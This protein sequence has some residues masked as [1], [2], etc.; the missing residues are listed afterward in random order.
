MN[1]PMVLNV[2][3][4]VS[5]AIRDTL[6]IRVGKTL[7]HEEA[8]RMAEMVEQKLPTGFRVMIVGPDIEMGILRF[9]E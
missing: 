2:P 6:V 3:W 1:T 9:A 7:T 8:S 4:V 5:V